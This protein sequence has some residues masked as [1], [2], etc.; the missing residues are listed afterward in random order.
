MQ[1]RE[2]LLHWIWKTHRFDF[3]NIKTSC[4]K[5]V[6]IHDSG[7][8]NKS[9]GPDFLGAEITIGNLRWYG[10]IEIHWKLSH[11]KAHGHTGD[12]NYDNVIL[13]VLFENSEQTISRND[14]SSIPNI[15]L[16]DYLDRPLKAFAEQY[17]KNPQLP[18][19]AQ[20]NFIS[21]EAFEKQ[22]ELAH[23]EYFEQKVEDLLNFYDPSMVPS[24]A[25]LKMFAVALFDGLGISHN[26]KPMQELG[27]VLFA[28]SKEF[29][30]QAAFRE[31]A[32]AS[33]E[34][35]K[36]GKWNRKGLRPGNRP[37]T[38]IQQAADC[39]F[40]VTRQPFERWIKN[41]GLELWN[42][43]MANISTVPSIG[44]QRNSILFGTV[45]LPSLYFLGNLFF[46]N[47]LKN[48]SWELWQGHKAEIP[49]S[50][51]SLFEK[52]KLPS[53]LYKNKLGSVHQIRDYCKPKK[54]Q[55][56]KVFKSAISS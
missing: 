2:E 29:N 7:K 32:I 30:S 19:S 33:A 31:F 9:D 20:L 28:K 16:A 44:R 34:I 53:H 8:L 25:W 54:C 41:D 51:L 14:G 50:L 21:T 35:H 4:G 12:P 17:Q 24:Q 26:R 45:F 10:D 1:F 23:K 36:D 48:R 3:Y 13:H 38:R 18:C 47:R 56:C 5:Q 37:E 40:Y 11:W 39:L 15:C 42:E 52:T 49:K 46:H 22:L 27:H 43:L 6:I 55:S